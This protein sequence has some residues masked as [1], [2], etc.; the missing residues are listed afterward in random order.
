MIFNTSHLKI[1]IYIVSQVTEQQE[2]GGSELLASSTS[3]KPGVLHTKKL[4]I[5]KYLAEFDH[6]KFHPFSGLESEEGSRAGESRVS[7]D[8]VCFCCIYFRPYCVRIIKM[9]KTVY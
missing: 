6:S 7:A 2:G 3:P 5:L 1:Y 4:L 8:C 9:K